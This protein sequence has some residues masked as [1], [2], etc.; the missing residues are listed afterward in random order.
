MNFIS[1]EEE[2][3]QVRSMEVNVPPAHEFNPLPET[4]TDQTRGQ[5]E[6]LITLESNPKVDN[7]SIP[8]TMET[9]QSP[10]KIPQPGTNS[11]IRRKGKY[12]HIPAPPHKSLPDNHS[13]LS[14]YYVDERSINFVLREVEPGKAEITLHEYPQ[15]L[16]VPEELLQPP[17]SAVGNSSAGTTESSEQSEREKLSQERSKS[18]FGSKENSG[19]VI[20]QDA[21]G[22]RDGTRIMSST[23][24]EGTSS[25][26]FSP[27][28]QRN[29]SAFTTYRDP[30]KSLLDSRNSS[31]EI[32]CTYHT[33]GEGSGVPGIAE[34]VSR[35]AADSPLVSPTQPRA[36]STPIRME[37][38]GKARIFRP[39]KGEDFED[40]FERKMDYSP[41]RFD[42]AQLGESELLP[43][44]T[45][46]LAS[47]KDSVS[48]AKKQ[49]EKVSRDFSNKENSPPRNSPKR[50]IVGGSIIYYN[51]NRS[52]T[53]SPRNVQDSTISPKKLSFA[54]AVQNHLN[55][56][57]ENQEAVDS[58]TQTLEE[59]NANSYRT[60]GVQEKDRSQCLR[61]NSVTNG[62][63]SLINSQL[64]PI[65]A[66]LPFKPMGFRRISERDKSGR[67]GST[68][69]RRETNV[70]PEESSRKELTEINSL[71]TGQ[72]SQGQSSEKS[73]KRTLR[74]PQI[75]PQLEAHHIMGRPTATSVAS[76]AYSP[77]AEV[78][79]PRKGRRLRTQTVFYR[80][81]DPRPNLRGKASLLC[82][83]LTFARTTSEFLFTFSLEKCYTLRV[84]SLRGE[85]SIPIKASPSTVQLG[86][87]VST[88][89]QPGPRRY[90]TTMEV[91]LD[92]HM[93][94]VYLRE[95]IENRLLKDPSLQELQREA[96]RA[97]NFYCCSPT[98]THQFSLREEY[99]NEYLELAKT[100]SHHKLGL[101]LADLRRKPAL[102]PNYNRF[103]LSDDL[104]D[105]RGQSTDNWS[106]FRAIYRVLTLKEDDF[107]EMLCLTCGYGSECVN[108]QEP[109]PRRS[110]HL[111]KLRD[112]AEKNLNNLEFYAA[113]AF[114]WEADWNLGTGGI[115]RMKRG[116]RREEI[117]KTEVSEVRHQPEEPLSI[118]KKGKA[119]CE[120][121][122]IPLTTLEELTEHMKQHQ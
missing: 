93:A 20:S 21:T 92:R 100:N 76:R 66:D 27:G 41:Y 80:S 73:S 86:G 11:D 7:L 61:E 52:G 19:S 87:Q 103:R 37:S 22:A 85:M 46:R 25:V 97:A 39:A 83:V 122:S 30:S 14:E 56:S 88:D 98:V 121:C 107:P 105:L 33:V 84:D 74:N 96:E 69:S 15:V 91:I 12:F 50:Q 32:F 81:E 89:I 36:T 8:N 43:E 48:L 28:K 23:G 17:D 59:E 1:F 65:S 111:A 72:S 99:C 113:K 112:E 6:N 29:S 51:S 115:E 47:S 67:S 10:N 64:G 4:T 57:Q 63:V 94:N 35:N 70:R 118:Y 102:S 24:R 110:T 104:E 95:E 71:E 16:P 18:P 90:P 68:G 42:R 78:I 44:P 55:K 108:S 3:E 101:Q 119:I 49:K 5:E 82:S 106:R 60:K 114:H 9:I 77:V 38:P 2:T 75:F 31:E 62:S 54:E 117:R 116:R 58:P 79:E 45:T 40:P 34:V 53:R 26:Y 109:C 13:Q 120:R